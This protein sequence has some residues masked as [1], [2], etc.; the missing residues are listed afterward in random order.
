MV[1]LHPVSWLARV[2]ASVKV[3]GTWVFVSRHRLFQVFKEVPGTVT[4]LTKGSGV[5]VCEDTLK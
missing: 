3:P 5:E 2:S 4:E 1:A